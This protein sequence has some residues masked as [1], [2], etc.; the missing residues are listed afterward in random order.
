VMPFAN[1]SGDPG[2]E[3]LSDGITESLINGLSH[4]PDLKVMSRDSAFRYKGKD[5]DPQ[6]IG[7]ELGVRA[8]FKGRVI[9]Q[10]D[11]LTLSAELIDTQ[12][13][14]QQWS[15][16]YS[17][18]ASDLLPLQSELA[19]EMT[20]AL[21]LHLSGEEEK[22]VVE[23]HTVNPE[24]YQL[25]LQGRYWYNKTSEEGLRNGIDYFM[26]AIAKDPAYALAYSG[27]AACH[28]DLA[29]FVHVHPSEGYPSAREAALE[30]LKR[31]NTIPEAHAVL[32]WIKATYDWDWSGGEQAFE[33]AIVL[34]PND[35]SARFLYG[36]MLW[37]Q[38]RTGSNAQLKRALEID[39]ISVRANMQLGFDSYFAGQYE[40]AIRQTRKAIELDPL[41]VPGHVVLCLSHLQQS[42]YQQ[43]IDA[44]KKMVTAFPNSTD[45]LSVLGYAYAV[46]KR[47]KDA[48]KVLV[49]LS[50]LADEN[51][52]YVPPG[53]VAAI[54]A[55]LGEK[56]Q[57][58]KWLNKAC[59][60]RSILGVGPFGY[61]KL[62][63]AFDPLRAD[64]R[65]AEL[66]RRVN[67]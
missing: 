32:G 42:S 45:A 20:M 29:E 2:N 15:K 25:Y 66:L 60:D 1:E 36:D 54:Y 3:Y 58:F 11:S 46:A 23:S 65:F 5:T 67:L 63:P 62:H 22:R 19:R 49:D 4:L 61:L 48:R 41:F 21:R 13:D 12:S 6:T 8:I 55:A 33:R 47:E 30:S 17:S 9:Q 64:P 28:N 52:R 38:G 35:A 27:L 59:E 51:N 34:N 44:V 39:P 18:K 57:A 43:G 31:D 37:L 14:T 10:G 53:S 56:D 26:Q 40:E 7:R 16:Q 24:A 50:A